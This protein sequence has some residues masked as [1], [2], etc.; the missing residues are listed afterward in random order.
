MIVRGAD[1]K[2]DYSLAVYTVHEVYGAD[3]NWVRAEGQPWIGNP[4]F[5]AR[6]GLVGRR[7]RVVARAP[8][9]NKEPGYSQ[10]EVEVLDDGSDITAAG[11]VSMNGGVF[12]G[13][14]VRTKTVPAGEGVTSSVA[15]SEVIYTSPAPF[16]A[17]NKAAAIAQI[18]LAAA[19]QDELVL[20]DPT[21]PVEVK[22][23][24]FGD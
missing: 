21:Q 18:L 20:D 14:V 24:Q 5:P 13:A 7:F 6:D 19:A 16:L 15:K 2:R 8:Q 10:W 17:L 22:L 11:G 4:W 1:R 3:G 12:V 23:L 9:N